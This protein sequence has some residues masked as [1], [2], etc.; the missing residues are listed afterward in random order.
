[1]KSRREV[2]RAITPRLIAEGW[3]SP[4]TYDLH[5]ASA[6]NIP[7]VYLFLLTDAETFDEVRVGYVGMSTQLR[8]RWANHEILSSIRAD[9]RFWVKRW[10]LP[11]IADD[12]RRVE[13]EYIRHFDPPWN[14]VGRVRGIVA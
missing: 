12:L 8:T 7:A 14:I 9:K 2:H 6:G 10:F 13:A 1:M 4:D 11:T 3:K 5:F